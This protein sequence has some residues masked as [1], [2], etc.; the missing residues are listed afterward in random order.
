MHI[1]HK[2]LLNFLLIPATLLSNPLTLHELFIT[3]HKLNPNHTLPNLTNV[4][5]FIKNNEHKIATHVVQNAL[6]EAC[7]LIHDKKDKLNTT[8]LTAL[9]NAIDT[10]DC[11]FRAPRPGEPLRGNLPPGWAPW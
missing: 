9:I 5:Q 1:L 6:E 2:I 11:A 10:Y 7:L 3:V 8:E 4:M